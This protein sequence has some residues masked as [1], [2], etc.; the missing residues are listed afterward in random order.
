MD[1]EK[2]FREVT[3]LRHAVKE[4]NK[5]ERQEL[6]EG[7]LKESIERKFRTTFIGALS[8]FEEEFGYLWGRGL[9]F[10]KL[11]AEQREE[12]LAW[13]AVRTKVLNN[14]N[15]QMRAAHDEISEYT[16]ERNKHFVSLRPQGNY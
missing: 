6:S 8:A 14:G 4:N 11:T 3:K 7:C 15:N 13:D 16:V 12:K 10:N 1:V 9:P 5:Q 2:N